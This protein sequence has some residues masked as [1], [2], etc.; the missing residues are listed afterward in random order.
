MKATLWMALV[1]SLCSQPLTAGD[2]SAQ[3][4][5]PPATA[6]PWVYWFWN[7]GNVTKAGIA[8]DLEAMKR[9]GIG[10]VII[11]DVVERFA[12]PPGTADFM[13]AEWQELFHYAVAEAHRLGLEVNMTNGPGWCGSSGPWIT[14]ELSMQRLVAT[15]LVLEGPAFFSGVLPRPDTGDKSWRDVFTSS[16]KYHDYYRDLAVLAFPETTNGVASPQTVRNLSA[17]LDADGKLKWKVP[18]GKW[19]IQRIG[20]TTTGASTRPPVKGGNGLECDKLSRQA[21]DVH[22]ANM[23]GK[24]ARSVGSLAGPTFTATHIDSWEVGAQNWTPNFRKEF[25]KR[26]GYDPMAFLPD[27]AGVKI[28]GAD[29]D[30][31][32]GHAAMARRFRW[33]FD[34]TASELLAENYVGR[35]AKLAHRRGLRLTL[36]G[37][38]LPFGDEATYTARADEPMTE[39][40]ATGGNENQAKGRQ[41]ASVAHIMGE[42]I[43]GAEAFTSDDSE[44][45]LMHPAA[46]KSLGDYEFAQGINRFVIHRYAH[47][48]YLNR[49]PGATMGPWGLHYER[50][51]TWWEMSGAWHT[52]LARCQYMLRQGMF[53]A[54]LCYLRPELPNQ[55]YFT[56][57]PAVP[58]GY[59]YDECSAEALIARMNV[60]NDR[61]VLPDGMSYRLLVLPTNGTLMTPALVKTIERL[62][63][64]GA[65]V[66]GPP[67]TASPSLSHFPKCDKEVARVAME[68]WGDCDGKRV[69]EHAFGKG[70]V[71]WGK[72]LAEVLGELRMPAD[73]TADAKL[74]WIHRQADQGHI[75]FV[76]NET[77]SAVEAKCD[78]R[79]Q[80]LR[81]ELWNPESGEFSPLAEYE[82]TMTG[83]A[84][85]L[86]LEAR[87]SVFVVFRPPSKPFDPVVSFTRDG[88][89]V[90]STSKPSVIKIQK[91]TYGVPGDAVRTRNVQTKMQAMVDRRELNFQ[92][93]ALAEGDD[94]AP[95]VVKTLVAEYSTDDQQFTVNA[96]DP[97]TVNL[98]ARLPAASRPAEIR[99]DT[100]GRLAIVASQP[101]RFKVKTASGKTLRAEI[102][103][104]TA[105]LEIGGQWDVRFPLNWG[106]PEQITLDHLG[107]LSAS[108]NA[109]VKFFSGTATYTK[110]FDWK[111]LAEP[112]STKTEGWLDLGE[113]QVM[114][115]VKLNGH[116]LGVLWKPPFRVNASAALHSGLNTLEIRVADLW[117]NRMIGDAALPAAERF[118]WSS[119]EPFTKDSPL[120]KSGLMGPVTLIATETVALDGD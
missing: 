27:V 16:I 108:T 54:D 100:A 55:T 83:I 78:F 116:D 32:V 70:Q 10:G 7:N 113:V 76:A 57:A 22:F 26:R 46:V 4:A 80:G 68:L 85:P 90:A 34:S 114:A 29:S 71:I 53:V 35:L 59:K 30:Y 40:W 107:S 77:P 36:E 109:G 119:Y 42:K 19:I 95:G 75:Y 69:T 14:P 66:L 103:T 28:P 117:P 81:P 18:A 6:R 25:K 51:Q 37:Y 62:V 91:A 2:L 118:T 5:N 8:A 13:N 110:T 61:L 82:A 94:P 104:V 106:A 74:N 79:V 12:P 97:D 67:P 33:D 50:T 102:A 98:V 47:Q 58:D 39:F 15:N 87:G 3:F 96:R 63:K 21:M 43:V 41:M 23:I 45:W 20:H 72:S 73:F 1:L 64:A 9:A 88:Q 56:P 112:G 115:Q 52:Y 92:V 120:P 24:L 105:P 17:K 60:T 11:M 93:A 48:P 101:G 86:R 44:Q 89:P 111:P 38:N 84:V 49:F 99:C 65:T 31:T